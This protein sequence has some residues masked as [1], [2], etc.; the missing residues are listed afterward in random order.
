[1]KHLRNLTVSIAC[2]RLPLLQFQIC[3]RSVVWA[4]TDNDNYLDP[5]PTLETV[6]LSLDDLEIKS[7][8]AV[9]GDRLA[10]V[11]RNAAREVVRQNLRT[12]ASY[13][14]MHCQNDI[15][16]LWSS[17]FTARQ[18]RSRIGFLSAPKNVR[19]VRGQSGR[20][21]LRCKPVYGARAGYTVQMAASL[22]GP[23]TDFC[24]SSSSRIPIAGLTPGQAY[25]FRLRA[26][27]AAGP[28]DWSQSVMFMAT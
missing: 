17:G 6:T 14:Q 2:L 26:S 28:S 24:T 16:I 21:T 5:F 22:D 27:G 3:G 23:Y 4:M 13:V 18:A 15:V 7:A 25:W 19:I 1:M 10:I 8:A 20:A 9:H 12:L 11:V